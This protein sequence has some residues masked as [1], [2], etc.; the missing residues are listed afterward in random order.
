[1]S[2]PT[3]SIANN[4]EDGDVVMQEDGDRARPSECILVTTQSGSMA[5]VVPLDE[6]L[7]RR[8]GALQNYLNGILDH[9]CGLNP[10][11]YRAVEGEGFGG[12]GVL[13]GQVLLRW[14]MLS[15]QR[16]NEACV[17]V[18]ADA[19]QMKADLAMISGSGLDYL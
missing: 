16:K 19:W 6:Q 4:G 2:L 3:T 17:R 5:L 12:R 10:R 14:G 11:S 18:G 9:P 1:M 7:Y 15:S 13:D 8:L